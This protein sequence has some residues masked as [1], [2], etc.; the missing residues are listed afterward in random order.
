MALKSLLPLM[1][2]A[3]LAVGST[4]ALA[5]VSDPAAASAQAKAAPDPAQHIRQLAR[6]FRQGDLAAMAE[7]ALPPSSMEELRLGIELAQL[8]PISDEDRLEFAEKLERATG[9]YAVDDLMAQIEPELEKARP[10]LPGAVMLGFGAIQM[11]ITSP[12]SKLTD[13]Q[14]EMIRLAV[15]NLQNWIARTDVLSSET[16]RQALTLMVDAARQT[17]ID[18]LEEI[19]TLSFDQMLGHGNRMLAAAKSAV[20]LYGI[21]LDAVADSLQVD[22][23]EQEG[24]AATVRTTVTLLGARLFADHDLRLIDG[25]WY[26]KHA[27]ARVEHRHTVEVDG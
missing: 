9:P 19:R 11:A 25:R 7:T 2:V 8:Q 5:A 1:L 22:V 20:R 4:P 27:A 13:E 10:Q 14:R 26:P 15:P 6:L 16:M 12:D 23:L 3:G 24:D 18:S 17:G 21:D